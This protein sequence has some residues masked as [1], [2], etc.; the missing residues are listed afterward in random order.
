VRRTTAR[1][2]AETGRPETR[3]LMERALGDADAS[4]RYYA[5]RGL[6]RIGTGESAAAIARLRSDPDVRVR[7][8]VQA[9]V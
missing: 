3:E 7:L 5:V 1:V 8:A 9:A 4:V 2:L 6:T